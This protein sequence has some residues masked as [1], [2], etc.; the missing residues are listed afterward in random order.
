M[1]AARSLSGNMDIFGHLGLRNTSS[2]PLETLKSP[3]LRIDK[4]ESLMEVLLLFL[5]KREERK[6]CP[7]LRDVSTKVKS[8]S[9]YVL[10]IRICHS[11]VASTSSEKGEEGF[12]CSW[13]GI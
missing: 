6:P 7:C 10:G 8:T 2:H 13:C 4:P 9:T 12:L 1:F 11:P 5:R 3:S